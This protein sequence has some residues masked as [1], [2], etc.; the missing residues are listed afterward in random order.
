[1]TWKGLGTRFD[2]RV[3][4]GAERITRRINRRDAL[5][6]AILTGAATVGAIALGQ[7]PAYA[8]I[9]CPDKCGPSPLCAAGSCPYTGCPSG[10]VLCTD[11]PYEC[12]GY[13]TYSSGSW[14][15]CKGYGTCG[16]GYT[17]C[18]D[19]KPNNSCHICICI[20]GV[21]C[22]QCCT[23]AQVRAEQKRIQELAAASS[24]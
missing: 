21:I 4:K 15:H 6:T 9:T 23:P 5:R 13:C 16:Y 11:P 19:C 10:Y 7:R 1:M 14:V 3:E 12:N 2:T 22:G 24:S 8:T 20:S 18:Q 17:L